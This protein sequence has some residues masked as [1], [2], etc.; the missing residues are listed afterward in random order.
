MRRPDLPIESPSYS[1]AETDNICVSVVKD[2]RIRQIR[3]DCWERTRDTEVP[4]FRDGGA[5][6]A[7]YGTER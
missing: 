7:A 2:A 3:A 6:S 1:R 5:K 4:Q